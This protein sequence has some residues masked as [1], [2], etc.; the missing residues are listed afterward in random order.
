LAKNKRDDPGVPL[1]CADLR[2]RGLI[3]HTLHRLQIVIE[4]AGGAFLFIR[5]E[6]FYPFFACQLP[7]TERN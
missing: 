1:L 6:T 3:S 2:L 4:A 5:S 7:E